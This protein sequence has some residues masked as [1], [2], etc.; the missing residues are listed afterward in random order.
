MILRN[1]YINKIKHHLDIFSGVFLVWHRQVGKTSIMQSLIEYNI[2]PKSHSV[3]INMDEISIWWNMI[4]ENTDQ[5]ISYIETYYKFDWNKITYLLIDEFKN[6]KNFNILLKSLIDKY[7][8]KKWICTSSWNY[9][10]SNEIVEW[11]AGRVGQIPIYPL[12]WSEYL[13][14]KNSK[15]ENITNYSWIYKDL[16]HEYMIYWWY[17]AVV[18]ATSLSS[19]K[20]IL[21]SIIDSTFSFDIKNFLKDEQVSD[22]RKLFVYLAENSG[23]LISY[24]WIGSTLWIKSYH[25]KKYID[26]L[27]NTNIIYSLNPYCTNPKKEISNKNKIYISDFGI[28]NFFISRRTLLNESKFI[29]MF[30]ANTIITNLNIDTKLYYRQNRNETEIDFI[31]YQN[32]KIIPIECK[33]NDKDIIPKAFHWFYD[34]YADRIDYYVKTSLSLQKQRILEDHMIV[35]IAPFYKLHTMLFGKDKEPL[36]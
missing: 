1:K 33:S 8:D 11:L 14:F 26:I 17:P 10:W 23:S 16:I 25:I 36:K 24:E 3:Y 32:N 7:K 30:V 29:E 6:I 22:I 27:I 2:I 34:T 19:K 4:F 13:V 12:D 28:M 5:F 31:L 21:K 15:S 18:L 35:K 9:Q 20:L